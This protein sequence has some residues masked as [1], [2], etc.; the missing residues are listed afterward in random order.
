MG[1]RDEAEIQRTYDTAHERARDA[2]RMAR[3]GD[4]RQAFDLLR[5]SIAGYHAARSAAEPGD[6]TPLGDAMSRAWRSM[7]VAESAFGDAC[8]RESSQRLERKAR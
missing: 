8:V 5:E 1:F 6:R 4:C 2:Y 7:N 3:G